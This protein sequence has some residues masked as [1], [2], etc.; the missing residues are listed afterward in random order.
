M[1]AHAQE[2]TLID[3]AALRRAHADGEWLTH[4]GDYA[5]TRFSSLDEINADNVDELE[6]VWSVE[7]GSRD[8]R[9]E[10]TP[11]VHDGVLYGTTTWSVTFAIDLRTQELKWIWDPGAVRG[12]QNG[13]VRFCCA[14]THFS[15]SVR[16]S[17]RSG[18]TRSGKSWCSQLRA[19][20]S[21]G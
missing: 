11:L 15:S 12:Q 16:R 5:E 17:S 3:D 4:G 2:D 18:A 6:L 8:G 13:G 1:P 20:C 21:C 19:I 9:Q 7:V 14:A 10:S